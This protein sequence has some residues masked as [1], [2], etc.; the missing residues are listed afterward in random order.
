M[1][2]QAS[3]SASAANAPSRI[4]GESSRRHRIRKDAV[5]GL[6][7]EEHLLAAHGRI[8]V[9]RSPLE[10]MPARLPS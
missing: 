3:N 6:L 9:L 2:T 5:H 8:R 10:H 1:P 4:I 7:A